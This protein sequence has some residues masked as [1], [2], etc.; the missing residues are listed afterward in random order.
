MT[1]LGDEWQG[2]ETRRKQ[3]RSTDNQRPTRTCPLTLTQVHFNKGMRGRFGSGGENDNDRSPLVRVLRRCPGRREPR[4]RTGGQKLDFDRLPSD[5]LF[6]TGQ[7][8]RV[9][10]EPP[11]VGSPKT[12]PSHYYMKAWEKAYASS[13]ENSIQSDV[14]T[15]DSQ[16]DLV[17]AY[18][19]D[20]HGVN[21][22]QQHAAGQPFSSSSSKAM[23]LN[24][25]T[26]E[27]HVI[28][29]DTIQLIDKNT[30]IRPSAAKPID[31]YAKKPKKAKKPFKLP[32][33]NIER[34]GFTGQ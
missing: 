23:Q 9:I 7:T 11:P 31:P 28:D 21:F 16:K 1:A 19:E 15:Y 18:G 30:G 14:I 10:Q 25:K 29:S 17:Y 12:A 20:G 8:L 24:P 26:G 32:T 4:C 3:P 2:A 33:M 34:R 5:G 27:V 6:L 13:N 22:A